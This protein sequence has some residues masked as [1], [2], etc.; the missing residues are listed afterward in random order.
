[1]KNRKPK[2]STIA[3]TT[4]VLAAVFTPLSASAQ[5]AT[6]PA[7]TLSA[8]AGRGF[9]NPSRETAQAQ[10][11]EK[12]PAAAVAQAP[13]KASNLPVVAQPPKLPTVAAMPSSKTPIDTDSAINPLTGKSF[14]E[15]RLTRLLNAN[16]LVTDI[17]RQQVAQAQLQ[18]EL[19]LTG[20]RRQAEAAKIRSEVINVIPKLQ[21]PVKDSLK[22]GEEF[23][24]GPGKRTVGADMPRVL[25]KGSM[26]FS[27]AAFG[28]P[29]GTSG[30]IRIGNE[31]IPAQ[32]NY[33][34]TEARVTYVDAQVAGA[35]TNTGASGFPAIPTLSQ[36]PA[37]MSTNS[38]S[39]P[40]NFIPG[41]M[42]R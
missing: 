17:A 11:E 21:V 26:P 10:T 2:L 37:G 9:M 41:P 42:Q 29:Q 7:E 39:F 34:G 22:A 16:K 24:A 38:G 4:A 31:S 36:N 25:P 5:L 6:K 23:I 30:S 33:S 1:M 13:E 18:T 28:T 40:S 35:R 3:A 20:D 32:S 15:E 12:A 27:L 8:G 14:S 19:E